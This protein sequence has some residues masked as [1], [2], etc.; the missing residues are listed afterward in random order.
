MRHC[1]FKIVLAS[2]SLALIAGT[3]WAAGVDEGVHTETEIPDGIREI[4]HDLAEA[5]NSIV[6]VNI[7]EG[8]SKEK[9]EDVLD[10]GCTILRILSSGPILE[11]YAAVEVDDTGSIAFRSVFSD[12]TRN[13]LYNIGIAEDGIDYALQQSNAYLERFETKAIETDIWRFE[14]WPSV[15]Q[16]AHIFVCAASQCADQIEDDAKRTQLAEGI[17]RIGAGGIIA[18][19]GGA[20][21]STSVGLLGL[22]QGMEGVFRLFF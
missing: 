13:M 1:S 19:V 10:N 14:Q 21:R 16:S 22:S 11:L 8:I 7:A 9:L 6:A 3:V 17:A 20:L 12:E 18:I 15:L 5:Y 4:S 2:L